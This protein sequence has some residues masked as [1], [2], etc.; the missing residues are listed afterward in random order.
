MKTIEKVRR[1]AKIKGGDRREVAEGYQA[2]EGHERRGSASLLS[3]S[4]L[5]GSKGRVKPVW[6]LP[7]FLLLAFHRSVV[8]SH[9]CQMLTGLR[10]S[11][12]AGVLGVPRVVGV[13]PPHPDLR[14]AHHGIIRIMRLGIALGRHLI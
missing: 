12:V 14:L 10:E 7:Q 4:R 1:T 9:L 5:N 2:F 8:S 13:D 3:Q 11:P 6:P